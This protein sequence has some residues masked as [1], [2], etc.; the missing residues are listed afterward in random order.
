MLDADVTK[1]DG[2]P[3]T[4]PG[5]EQ[6]C[7]ALIVLPEA[8]PMRQTQNMRQRPS[9][10]F[11]TQLIANAQSVAQ[12]RERRRAEPAE[13]VICYGKAKAKPAPRKPALSIKL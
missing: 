11:L 4:A 7:R 1:K 8:E 5:Q 13:A 9:V 10:A 2:C 12:T 3:R 6:E